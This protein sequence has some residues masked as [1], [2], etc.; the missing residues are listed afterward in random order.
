MPEVDAEAGVYPLAV[1]CPVCDEILLPKFLD[2]CQECGHVFEDG[3]A[4]NPKKREKLPDGDPLRMAIVFVVLV[5]LLG[6]MLL[7]MWW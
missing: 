1:K 6:L 7:A 3:I 2:T 5:A 4:K